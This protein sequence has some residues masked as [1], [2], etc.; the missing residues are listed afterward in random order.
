MTSKNLFWVRSRENNKRRIWV[1]IVSI[2]LQ[3]VSYPAVMT[4]YLSRIQFWNKEGMY[5]NAATKTAYQSALYEAA[6][7]AVGFQPRVMWIILLLAILIGIQG[8]SYLY[9]RRKVDLYHSVPVPAKSRYAVIYVNGILCYL[10]PNV[11][12]LVTALGI[13]A[14]QKAVN[15]NVLVE[16][17]YAFVMNLL[18]FL[19]LYHMTILAV[20]LTG[21]RV[22]TGFVLFGLLFADYFVVWLYNGMQ[23]AFFETADRFFTSY[24]TRLS[25]IHDYDSNIYNLKQATDLGNIGAILVPLYLKWAVLAAICGILAYVCYQRR[26]SET[27]GKAIAFE[28]VKPVLK[29]AVAVLM[30]VA[31]CYLV[32]D[33]VYYNVW[34]TV[35]AMLAGTLLCCG[36]MEVIYEFDIRAVMKH[37]VSTGIS[38]AAVVFIFVIYQFDILGYDSYIPAAEDVES[39]AL[40]TVSYYHDYF[41]EDNGYEYINTAEYY[42]QNMFLTSVEEVCELA[43]KAQITD[44]EEMKDCREISVLYRLKSGREVGR[45]FY[46]DF[47]EESNEPLLNQIVGSDEYLAGVYQIVQ[48]DAILDN[49]TLDITYSNGII[50]TTLSYT[51]ARALKEAWLKDMKQFDYSFARHNRICGEI[52]LFFTDYY[53]VWTLPVY[54]SFANTIAYLKEK[55]AFYPV[56][57]NPEDISSIIVTNYHNDEENGAD[58]EGVA[59]EED[60]VV[61]ETFTSPEEIAEIAAH[62]YPN[63]LELI[64]NPL[65]ATIGEYEVMVNFKTGKEYPYGSAY[66]YFQFVKDE[67]PEFVQE[68][69]ALSEE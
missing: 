26:K 51:D 47:A 16:C 8:F 68:A 36:A 49:R 60:R 28:K 43:R 62:I 10:L 17:G 50:E 1:W 38:V 22:I 27:A 30:G 48:A 52:E 4:M 12:S 40:S 37:L 14:T 13:A 46:V 23:T 44:N 67:V 56:N 6:A 69:T 53:N 29:I 39:I 57:I 25:P 54:D 34:I 21:N 3:L 31:V 55:N 9:D 24:T 66:Y 58:S 42:R 11:V 7:D 41:V 15:Y 32:Y 33:A 61:T 45:T 35:F 65:D 2:L 18:F 19:F 20:M 5:R 64:W 59:A 63:S